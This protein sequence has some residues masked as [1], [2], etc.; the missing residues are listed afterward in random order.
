MVD[1]EEG[2]YQMSLVHAPVDAQDLST[3]ALQAPPNL[4]VEALDWLDCFCHL[5][6]KCVVECQIAEWS[7]S[8]LR[9]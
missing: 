1:I 4:D 5:Q 8:S 6:K 2:F 3:V 9:S 7:K